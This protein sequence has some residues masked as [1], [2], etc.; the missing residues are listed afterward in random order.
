[1]LD[2]ISLE[3]LNFIKKNVSA[4]DK[5]IQEAFPGL[6][7]YSYISSFLE[8]NLISGVD[9]PYVTRNP[10]TNEIEEKHNIIAPYQITPLGNQQ[11]ENQ[12]T[13]LKQNKYRMIHDWV[14]TIIA[15]FAMIAAIIGLF[16]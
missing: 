4:S 2:K 15:L 5:Q 14:N 10:F 11:I 12:A 6:N 1:M 8:R 9:K 3:I 7:T 13:Y 16:V